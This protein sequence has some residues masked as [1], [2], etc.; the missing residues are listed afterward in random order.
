MLLIMELREITKDQ[1]YEVLYRNHYSLVMPR[2]TK[3]C[4]G[5]FINDEIVG[6]A[7]LGWGTQPKLTIN[8]LVP[9][10]V[11]EDYYELGKFA[12]NEDMPKNS[13][14]QFLS[15]IIKWMKKNTDKLYL[16]T[17]ADGI[18]GKPGYIYQASNFLYGG[19]RWSDVYLSSKGEKIHPRS[20]RKFYDENSQMEGRHVNWLT[21]R[22]MLEKGLRHIRG[23]Q[24]RY[25]YPLNR[26]AKKL[27]ETSQFN[28]TTDYPKDTDLKWRDNTVKGSPQPLPGM[29]FIDRNVVEVNKRNVEMH[30][31]G[32][33]LLGL[34]QDDDV[35]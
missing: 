27:L 24:F 19:Y 30:S 35:G 12:M 31:R 17:W 16:F 13:E 34:T 22:Y 7:T 14:S 28:W 29:P 3:V 23:R 15:L 5:V 25:I 10:L 21:T 33:G 2:L 20:A 32:L 9:G 11:T 18:M 6:A 4:L 8:K 1:A 26:R